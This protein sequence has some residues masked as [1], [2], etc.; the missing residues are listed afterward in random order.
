MFYIFCFGPLA[1]DES[2][3]ALKKLVLPPR[4]REVRQEG[5]IIN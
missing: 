2:F 3:F 5:A 4:N 1:R